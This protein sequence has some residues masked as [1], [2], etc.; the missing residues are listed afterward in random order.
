VG[1]RNK[2][3]IEKRLPKAPADMIYVA[4]S[5]L[6]KWCIILKEADK[7]RIMQTKC[8]IME[9]LKIFKPTVVAASD[10]YMSFKA[11]IVL[12]LCFSLNTGIPS[13][14]MVTLLS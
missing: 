6:Q 5:L 4:L 3:A 11:V 13:S 2:M 9:W 14:V 10:V 7:E 1:T 12:V 8:N